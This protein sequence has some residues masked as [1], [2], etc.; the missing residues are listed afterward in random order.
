MLLLILF[1]ALV[2]PISTFAQ[3]VPPMPQGGNITVIPNEL[4][5]SYW[6]S[7]GGSVDVIGKDPGNQM[8]FSHDRYGKP[9]G[10]GLIN[11]PFADRPLTVP[12][13]RYRTD[14]EID[15]EICSYLVRC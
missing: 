7:N 4:G 12:E 1:I 14:K 15:R 10:M 3:S 9:N 8:Y 2:L 6:S 5:A 13:S 11:Q